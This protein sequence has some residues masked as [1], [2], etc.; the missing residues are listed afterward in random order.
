MSFDLDGFPRDA[1]GREQ[2]LRRDL[3]RVAHALGGAHYACCLKA[4]DARRRLLEDLEQVIVSSDLASIVENDERFHACAIAIELA[5]AVIAAEEYAPGTT[6]EWHKCHDLAEYVEAGIEHASEGV[7][8]ERTPAEARER[9][10]RE[11]NLSLRNIAL[12]AAV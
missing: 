12:P 5:A 3:N 6:P 11:A 2:F 1:G 4:T 9:A 7:F 8:G 10:V